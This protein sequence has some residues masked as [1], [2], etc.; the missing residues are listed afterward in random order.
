MRKPKEFSSI[1][2]QK[3][4]LYT[5]ALF[6][7]IWLLG[8]LGLLFFQRNFLLSQPFIVWIG[9]G[10]CEMKDWEVT[11]RNEFL[12]W[13]FHVN[14]L[15]LPF[16]FDLFMTDQSFTLTH[17][18]FSHR[19]DIQAQSEVHPLLIHNSLTIVSTRIKKYV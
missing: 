1:W 15:F 17:K 12:I 8:I 7:G 14:Q 6:G 9:W 3:K 18:N 16:W 19:Q 11:E 5:S 4:D 10:G 13:D 2:K